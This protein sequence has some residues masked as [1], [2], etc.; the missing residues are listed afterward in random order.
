MWCDSVITMTRSPSSTPNSTTLRQ[1][2]KMPSL[3]APL[4]S[5]TLKWPKPP[6]ISVTLRQWHWGVVSP[7][8]VAAGRKH[9]RLPKIKDNLSRW[10]SDVTGIWSRKWD[11]SKFG[12]WAID[13]QEFRGFGTG[14]GSGVALPGM[15]L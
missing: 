4:P 7:F 11:Q 5:H 1:A 3:L 9:P 6:S 15:Q 13:V 10:Q 12:N 2:L 14:L 8:V